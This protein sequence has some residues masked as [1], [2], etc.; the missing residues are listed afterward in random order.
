MPAKTHQP[1]SK[2]S[3]FIRKILSDAKK[4]IDE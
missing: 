2:L 4:C 3:S 1:L